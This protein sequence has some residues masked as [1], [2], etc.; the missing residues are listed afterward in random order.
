M[1]IKYTIEFGEYLHGTGFLL[2]L[3]IGVPIMY[4]LF[5]CKPTDRQIRQ[6][7]KSAKIVYQEVMP[8]VF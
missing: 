3:S 1:K 5:P 8:S 6:Y 7:I 4:K 2:H